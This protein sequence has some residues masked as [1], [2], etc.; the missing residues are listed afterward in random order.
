MASVF[1]LSAGI[2]LMLRDTYTE[3]AV[4]GIIITLE[5]YFVN[6]TRLSHAQRLKRILLSLEW[7]GVEVDFWIK[8]YYKEFSWQ[9]VRIKVTY[10]YVE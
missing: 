7:G 6:E 2:S 5:H 9:R 10:C 1:N 3:G 4:Q 8:E